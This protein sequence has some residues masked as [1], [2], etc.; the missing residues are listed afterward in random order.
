MKFYLLFILLLVLVSCDYVSSLSYK[1]RN[2]TDA[3]V[4]VIATHTDTR[5][6]TDTILIDP[7]EQ[8]VIGV[9]GGMGRVSKYREEYENL[10]H[11]SK[12]E[13]S[14]YESNISASDF[15]KKERWVYNESDKYIADYTL[16]VLPG[17]F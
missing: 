16:T 12:I 7:N 17:D 9:K 2:N 14:Q 13:I 3:P 6:P 10:G 8:K 4:K 5:V 11:F 1:V 15:L